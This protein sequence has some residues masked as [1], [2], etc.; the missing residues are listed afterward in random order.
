MSDNEEDNVSVPSM[1]NPLKKRM[2]TRS[3]KDIVNTVK[4][5]QQNEYQ[6]DVDKLILF[7]VV[8][9]PRDDR[10]L[11]SEA[12][13]DCSKKLPATLDLRKHLNA[14]RDQSNQGTSAAQVAACMKEWQEKKK[15]DFID[16]MSPQFIY[17]LS[18]IHI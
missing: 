4:R 7:N 8:P 17:N 12:I 13:Y 16:Y 18:L 1:S 3:M 11:N 14:P 10:D 6:H 9:S 15:G 5:I 2:S